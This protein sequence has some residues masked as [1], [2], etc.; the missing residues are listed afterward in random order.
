MS[1]A[2]L[3]GLVAKPQIA[4]LAAIDALPGVVAKQVEDAILEKALAD[5]A[6]QHGAAAGRAP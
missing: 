6:P 5:I 3:P 2:F 4:L 1:A